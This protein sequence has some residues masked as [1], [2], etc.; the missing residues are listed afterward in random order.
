MLAEFVFENRYRFPDQAQFL[1][2]RIIAHHLV[3]VGVSRYCVAELLDFARNLRIFFDGRTADDPGA[4]HA[5]FHKNFKQPPGTSA[6]AILPLAVIERI[7]LSVRENDGCF[8]RLVMHADDDGEPNA[9][10]PSPWFLEL[11]F[12][13][14]RVFLVSF[15]AP[16]RDLTTSRE[17]DVVVLLEPFNESPQRAKR[18]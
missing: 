2:G 1:I 13:P 6:T 3:L 8:F 5:V 14:H 4:E 7:G 9:L 15:A 17:L 16:L 12:V 18:C 10:R 11:Y